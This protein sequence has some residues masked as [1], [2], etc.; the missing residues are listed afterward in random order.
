[1]SQRVLNV[2]T[3]VLMSQAGFGCLERVLNVLKQF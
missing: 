2:L 3:G 1:M